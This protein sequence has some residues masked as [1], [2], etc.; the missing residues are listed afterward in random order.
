MTRTTT[1]EEPLLQSF[2]PTSSGRTFDSQPAAD[3]YTLGS[4][5]ESGFEIEI[6]ILRNQVRGLTVRPGC[7]GM[8]YSTFL[9]TL[10]TF[11]CLILGTL[12]LYPQE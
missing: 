5:T 7:S 8:T 1:Q 9:R 2:S 3:P 6:G 12:Y 4:S 10:N 11:F